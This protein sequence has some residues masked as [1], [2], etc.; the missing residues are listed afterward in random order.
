[1]ALCVSCGINPARKDGFCVGCFM[2]AGKQ[3][4]IMRFP[5][6]KLRKKKKKKK[7]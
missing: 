6:W 4:S 3:L 1:M 2:V 7:K 5:V